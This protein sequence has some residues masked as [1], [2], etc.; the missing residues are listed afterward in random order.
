MTKIFAIIPAGGIGNR[1][2]GV[3]KKQ[4]LKLSG[5][6]LLERT[7]S[8]FLD[9]G[10]FK[11]IVV[12]LPA[13]E[14]SQT[15]DLPK[16]SVL[17]Y[18]EGGRSRAESVYKGFCH[19]SP[20]A[21]D[22]VLIHDAVRPLVSVGLIRQIAQAAQKQGSAI[23]VVPIQDTVKEVQNGHV[24][25]TLDRKNLFAVQTPQAFLGRFLKKAYSQMSFEDKHWTDE[26][27][28]VEA[29]GEKIHVVE[30]DKRNI[31]ITTPLDLKIAEV[32]LKENLI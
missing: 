13:D 18:V 1:F 27:M 22:V 6:T 28:L 31:K 14:L 11:E 5:K 12:C 20:Q 4:F 3:V 26:A 10:I 2:G 15:D 32:L 19:L 16:A 29:L 9:S 7:L 30:G 8:P 24:E 21:D 25:R 23:P 17:S